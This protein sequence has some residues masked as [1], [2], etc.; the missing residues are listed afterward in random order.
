[1]AGTVEAVGSNVTEFEPGDEVYG[2]CDGSFA[3]C[4]CARV[5]L[6]ALKAAN[7]SFE[8]AAAVPVS[9]VT[10]SQ[11]VR[12]RAKVRAGENV[13]IIGASGG[14]GTFAIQIAKALGA[15]VTGVC[16]PAKMDLVRALGAD[17]VVDYTGDD[18]ADGE[19]HYDAILDIAGN[20]RLSHLRRALTPK[21]RLVIV[22]GE[23]DGQRLGGL[24]ASS[25]QSCFLRW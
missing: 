13:L 16:S 5:G 22:G 19:H 12:D 2:T 24:T 6:L 10:A 9:A 21:G 3:E 11:G 17:Q 8:Q 18:F 15:E 14:V 4:A 25:G 23:T 1:L 20:S 7:L